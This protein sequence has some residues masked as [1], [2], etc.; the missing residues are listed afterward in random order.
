M[1]WGFGGAHYLALIAH[2]AL[3]CFLW[4]CEVPV[5]ILHDYQRPGDVDP[6]ADALEPCCLSWVPHCS[7]SVLDRTHQSWELVDNV[8][9]FSALWLVLYHSM[10]ARNDADIGMVY[11]HF[12]DSHTMGPFRRRVCM[13]RSVT[14]DPRGNLHNSVHGNRH[15]FWTTYYDTVIVAVHPS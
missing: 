4:F 8:D 14:L 9:C 7:M 1:W 12:M 6:F 2:V 13:L 3:L 15:P 10:W 5:H 11:R